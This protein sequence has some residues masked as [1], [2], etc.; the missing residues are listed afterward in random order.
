[1]KKAL[2]NPPQLSISLPVSEN[3][4][5][6]VLV[7][8]ENGAATNGFHLKPDEFVGN[9]DSFIEGCRRAGFQVIPPTA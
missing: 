5:G 2:Q 3:F 9:V 7:N 8:V 6:K 1:M 4:T